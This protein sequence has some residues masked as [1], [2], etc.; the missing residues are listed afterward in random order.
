MSVRSKSSVESSTRNRRSRF[1]DLINQRLLSLDSDRLSAEARSRT[2]LEDFG[3]TEIASR[4]SVLVNSLEAEASLHLL[5]R[6]LARM[7]L[8]DLLETRL[9]LTHDWRSGRLEAEPIQRPIFI[10]G[11]PRSG[12][13]F[14]HELL[15]QDPGSRVP[16]VWEVMF[17]LALAG[18]ADPHRRIRKTAACLWCFRRIAPRADAVHPLRASMPHECI[19]IHSY[20][21]L[22]REFMTAFNVPGYEAFLNTAD[23]TPAYAWQKRFLQHLQLQHPVKRWVLK[24]P[25]HVYSMDALFAVFPDALIIQTHRNPIEVLKSS[26][27]LT[28]V[29]RETFGRP[30]PRQETGAREVRV[31]ADGMEQI[32]R[33]RDAHPELSDRFFDVSYQQIVSDPLGTI[34]WF[35]R[36]AGL[37]LTDA[38]ADRVRRLAGDRS[39]YSHRGVCPTLADFGI[40]G[41]A[42][43]SRFANYCGRF[44]SALQQAKAAS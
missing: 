7:H 14:L 17:P 25:D 6:F 18:G 1:S 8:R 2:G 9:R 21:L 40:D 19:A 34:R 39:R 42:E 20:T 32:T 44:S 3:D 43:V 36:Q 5:G 26:T 41:T 23:F 13:S 30:R 38:T 28:E 33:F 27:Q 24:A 10:T 29:V 37:P 4:L 31:L 15:A 12:S 11:M 16:R 22:S 35:Y